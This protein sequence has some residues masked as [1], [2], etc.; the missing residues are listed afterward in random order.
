[1]NTKPLASIITPC[2]NGEKHVYRFLDSILIQTYSNIELIF[3]N[4]GST[5]NTEHVVLSY[6]EKLEN[7]GIRLI[8]ISQENKGLGGAI[9]AGLKKVTGKYICWPDSDDYF[10]PE[11][12]EL[13]LEI[14]EKFPEFSVV[15][16]D[17]YIRSIDNLNVELGLVSTGFNSN[18]DPFQFE[19]LLNAN[20][21]FCSGT[22]MMRTQAFFETHPSGEIFPSRRGQNWQMLLPVYYLHKRYFLNRPLYN[23]IRYDASMSKI[24]EISFREKVITY[25]NHK[26]ILLETLSAMN[27]VASERAKYINAVN[28]KYSLANFRLGY[29]HGDYELI[30]QEYANLKRLNQVTLKLKSQF[31]M[32]R[33][34]RVFFSYFKKRRFQIG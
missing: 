25:N 26:D 15:T 27:I 24:E 8:Y 11:S 3:V 34:N 14:L 2:Y 4:D 5:D 10:E 23:Y 13:R 9:N 30:N 21:I 12:I 20:S 31:L 19:H 1:M 16:S 28:A 17:A 22:H 6:K 18:N 33:L 29:Y 7:K 32:A